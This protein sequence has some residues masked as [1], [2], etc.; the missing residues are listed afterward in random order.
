MHLLPH[1]RDSLV[2]QDPMMGPRLCQG[3]LAASSAATSRMASP[4]DGKPSLPARAAAAV[5]VPGVCGGV[6][7]D[8][9]AEDVER[10]HEGDSPLEHGARA[11]AAR[12]GGGHEGDGEEDEDELDAEGD[13]EHVVGWVTFS[14]LSL[15]SLVSLGGGEATRTPRRRCSQQM[16]TADRI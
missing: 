15:A 5:P 9:E 2:I 12:E 7:V 1:I 8:A 13:E 10:E 6:Q 4:T 16:K 3:P 14:F 11:V